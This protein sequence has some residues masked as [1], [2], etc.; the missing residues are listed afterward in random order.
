M[1]CFSG[2]A[3]ALKKCAGSMALWSYGPLKC[4]GAMALWSA[5]PLGQLDIS[6][7]VSRI[8]YGP[9]WSKAVMF[10]VFLF[11]FFFFAR[12]DENGRRPARSASFFPLYYLAASV[13]PGE[14]GFPAMFQTNVFVY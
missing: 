2:I 6:T 10:C 12:R 1:S 13:S 5:N 11:S 9:V 7:R 14:A 3:M 4:A 8:S